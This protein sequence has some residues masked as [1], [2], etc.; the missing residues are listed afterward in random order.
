MQL[1]YLEFIK[2]IDF[3][4]VLDSDGFQ[5]LIRIYLKVVILKKKYDDTYSL[6]HYFT[7][8]INLVIFNFHPLFLKVK[9]E[10]ITLQHIRLLQ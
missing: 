3:I 9:I 1:Y 4:L 5:Y 10:N 6:K 7:L 8:S 2:E